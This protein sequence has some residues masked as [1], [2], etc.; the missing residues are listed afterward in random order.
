[1]QLIKI[2]DEDIPYDK[3][4]KLF[5]TTKLSRPHYAPEVCVKVNMLNFMVTEQGLK[6]QMLTIVL[7][8][9]DKNNMNKRE[10][11]IVKSAQN[12]KKQGELENIILDQIA[13]AGDQILE[14]D[15]LIQTLDESKVQQAR[16]KQQLDEAEHIKQHIE[17]VSLTFKDVAAR[18]SSLFFV[19]VQIMNID[20]MYQYSLTSY[21][22][23]YQNALNAAAH[24]PMNRKP[25]RKA[26]FIDKFT[27]LL[28]DN[29]CR[30]LFE[31]D[32]LL[33][34]FLLCLKIMEPDIDQAEVRFI[35]TGSTSVEMEKPNPAGEEGWMSD[36]IWQSILQIAREFEA[37]DGLDS[38]FETNVDEWERIYNL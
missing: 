35:M 18:G 14:D 1:M 6:E 25:E 9:E 12:K 29:I 5:I 27:E 24:I 33:F 23:I 26:F 21:K 36:K 28:Y 2:G 16:I 20:P 19:L 3:D 8:N 30:S 22:N 4:F 10:E 13:S 34:S 11:A 31:K 38:N 17:T 37:F 15:L 7:Y 32:K